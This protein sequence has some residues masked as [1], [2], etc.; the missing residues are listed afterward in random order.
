MNRP[1]S[2]APP[3]YFS[4]VI[5]YDGADF[6][7]F[8]VQAS[9]RTVQGEIEQTL[10]R[11]TQQSVRVVGAGRTDAGVHAV[12][13]VIAFRVA[14]KHTPADLQRALNALL[15]ADIAVL[16]LEPAPP[17]FHPRFSAS[18]R[19]YRYQVG[20][21]PGHS[22]LRA[23]YAWELGP[24]ID[25]EAMNQAAA[26]LIGSHDFLTFGQPPQDEPTASTV[27]RVSEARWSQHPPYLF[28]DIR[29]NAFLRRMVRTIVATLVQVGQG[30]MT[31]AEVGGL[32]ASRERGLA[33][34]PAPAQ[35]LILISVAYS[36][37]SSG[38]E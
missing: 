21:W 1:A 30:R 31:P 36:L 10:H 27:R 26:H 32:L 34:P 17:E 7:G 20:Q 8:Q 18:E 28:F 5:E 25:V 12:G 9:G 11:L 23:R 2:S 24:E 35:G 37:P 3:A 13:Q 33:P 38:V 6:L 15:P 16:H 22:P 4:A 19:H 14:W 29:A